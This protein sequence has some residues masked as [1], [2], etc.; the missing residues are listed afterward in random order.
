MDSERDAAHRV[1][2]RIADGVDPDV[3]A[4]PS[5]AD[6]IAHVLRD[7]GFEVALARTG[8][9][10]LK[11]FRALGPD[12]ILLDLMIPGINGLEVCR[13]IRRTS[14]VPIIIVTARAGELEKV[15]GREAG[16][17]GYLTKPFS[18]TELRARI[19]AVLRRTSHP[20]HPVGWARTAHG[21]RSADPPLAPRLGPRGY[22]TRRQRSLTARLRR[23]HP[24]RGGYQLASRRRI[25]SWSAAATSGRV[26]SISRNAVPNIFHAVTGS[27]AVTVAVRRPPPRIAISPKKSPAPRVLSSSA[28]W[29]TDA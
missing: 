9:E 28:S 10:G 1:A 6:T 22:G 16:A 23:L 8:T 15:V 11:A 14:D 18:I 29:E 5:L 25:A 24:L 2:A 12:L 3:L 20:T 26:F 19:R 27:V 4:E 17:D 7:D 13:T 21:A